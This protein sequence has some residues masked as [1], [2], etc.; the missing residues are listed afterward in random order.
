MASL[1]GRTAALP[2]D[3]LRFERDAAVVREESFRAPPQTAALQS[4]QVR[5]GTA[6]FG[7]TLILIEDGTETARLGPR[8]QT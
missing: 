5:L 3:I 8:L 6:R 2:K 4:A 1:T 7:E